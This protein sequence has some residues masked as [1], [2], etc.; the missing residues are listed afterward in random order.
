ML[1]I[2]F[3]A[4][5]RFSIELGIDHSS[6]FDLI[7]LRRLARDSVSFWHKC[8]AHCSVDAKDDLG[9]SWILSPSVSGF[10]SLLL[11]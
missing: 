8:Q 9:T 11:S 4:W 5:K 1:K 6:Q 7:S 3:G 10:S 2:I